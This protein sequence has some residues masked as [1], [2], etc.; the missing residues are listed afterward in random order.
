[1]RT[2]FPGLEETPRDELEVQ[3][4]AWLATT[5]RRLATATWVGARSQLAAGT[6]WLGVL[7]ASG[8]VHLA[9][10]PADCGLPTG[11][12]P[13]AGPRSA[14]P[15]A[16]L[17]GP[18]TVRTAVLPGRQPASVGLSRRVPPAGLPRTR[19]TVVPE[20]LGDRSRGRCVGAPHRPGRS[21]HVHRFA[22]RRRDS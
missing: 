2:P 1:M 11:A 5:T 7:G 12:L 6:A 14:D 8:S 13:V 9:L 3:S 18:A 4:A 17:T 19:Q 15:L 16:L 10:C 21:R 22:S 20:G